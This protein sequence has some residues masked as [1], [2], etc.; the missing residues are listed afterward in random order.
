MILDDLETIAANSFRNFHAKGLDY[1][2]LH[3]SE[4]LT[5]KAYFYEI[6][7]HQPP[8][9]ICPHDHRYPFSTHILAGESGHIRYREMPPWAKSPT[10]Q[11]FRW[12][13]PLLGG[14][15]FEWDYPARL[16]AQPVE[17]YH[18]GQSY[19]CNADEIHTITIRHPNTVLLLYQH[20]DEVPSFGHTS[21]FVP[22]SSREPPRLDGLY[23]RMPLDQA[24]QRLAHLIQLGLTR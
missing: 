9:V 21:T 16:D 12:R 1:L 15:G 14:S 10:H 11:C 2:C 3:R 13:T 7:D 4:V 6:G 19:W 20:A 8:E 18:A 23:D 22:G 17:Q 5:I 24:E